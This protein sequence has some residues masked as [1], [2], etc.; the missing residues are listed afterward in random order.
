MLFL[1]PCHTWL[2]VDIS[3]IKKSIEC[4][5]GY[6]T[7]IVWWI[8]YLLSICIH[9]LFSHCEAIFFI[10]IVI[11]LLIP[12]SYSWYFKIIVFIPIYIYWLFYFTTLLSIYSFSIFFKLD[13]FD[14]NS[15]LSVL[16]HDIKSTDGGYSSELFY[17]PHYVQL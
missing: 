1:I 7:S 17:N 6:K 9:Y 2:S 4:F 13:L 14:I 8:I 16:P 11:F 5:L 10:N 3:L 15:N 12:D